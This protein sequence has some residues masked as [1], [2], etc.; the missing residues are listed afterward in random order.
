MAE[1]SSGM[2]HCWM[3][4]SA[5]GESGCVEVRYMNSLVQVRDSKDPHGDILE[6][7]GLEWEAFLVGVVRGEFRLPGTTLPA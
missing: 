2:S 3:K 4:S 1:L 7:T 5:S 6:F